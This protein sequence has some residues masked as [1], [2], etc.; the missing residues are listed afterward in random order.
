VIWAVFIAMLSS[1]VLGAALTLLV[2]GLGRRAALL[3][4]AGA[5]G[6]VKQLRRVP[7]I[8]GIAVFWAFTLPLAAGLVAAHVAPDLVARL[9]PAAAVHLDG[10]RTQAPLALSLLM[11][12]LV[13]HVTGLIDDRK[14]LGPW[15]K[16]GV[17][18]LVAGGIV[19][20]TDV[21]I[22]TLLDALAGGPWLSAL[23]TALWIVTLTNAMN[24]MDNMDGL[25]GGVGVTAA[26][27]LLATAL[28]SGQWFVAVALA[29][30]VGALCGFL[31]F[32]FPWTERRT[33][34]IFMGDGG[35][36]VIGFVLAVLAARVTYVP[37]P[38]NAAQTTTDVALSGQ[39]SLAMLAPLCALAIP[40][41]DLVSVTLI[42]LSQGRSPLVGDRQHFSHRLHAAGLSVRR[43]VLVICGCTAITGI[44]GVLLAHASLWQAALAL[45]QVMLVLALIALYE[46]GKGWRDPAS[47]TNTTSPAAE[48]RR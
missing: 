19:A 10:V 2:R 17:Q 43:T 14:A 11:A 27:A 21:R 23:V 9:V 3:D 47:R 4:S 35:S 1:G 45:V 36:L 38:T 48:Q 28:A 18:W 37:A 24:F 25:A 8:G 30:L 6:H 33:A 31:V 13:L 22:L 20:I 26:L 41:Y 34:T 5:T 7:N 16:F 29:T 39:G 40:L 46:H 42:R 12:A 15:L 44:T 32:N